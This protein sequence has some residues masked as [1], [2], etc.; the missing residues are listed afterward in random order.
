MGLNLF[1]TLLTCMV[2]VLLAGCAENGCTDKA[3]DNYVKKARQDDGS[4]TYQEKTDQLKSEYKLGYASLVFAN[5]QDALSAAINLQTEIELF[6][7]NPTKDGLQYC[8]DAWLAARIPYGQTEAFRFS[9]GPIDDEGGPEGLID[10]WP[11][12]ASYIDYVVG[13]PD[14]GIINDLNGFPEIT[15]EALIGVNK[16]DAEENVS[17]GYH[18][19]EFLLWG[20]D[21]SAPVDLIPGQRS[22]TDYLEVDGTASNQGRRGD[23]LSV[24]AQVLIDQLQVMVDAWNPSGSGNYYQTFMVLSGDDALQNVLTGLATLS[25]SELAEISMLTAIENQ[26]ETGPSDFSDNTQQDFIQNAKGMRNVYSAIYK[27]LDGTSV[28][29]TSIYDV[30]DVE[31]SHLGYLI[32]ESTK[33]CI[34]NCEAIPTPFDSQLTKETVEGSKPIMSAVKSL[35]AQGEMFIEAGTNLGL[36]VS[37]L[38][39]P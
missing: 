2:L 27:K 19:I 30:L 5:Y 38:S 9:N 29:G 20:Q 37:V 25:K 22:S 28:V 39:V 1:R 11:M 26:E 7:E 6:L 36:T 34:S 23:Y 17:V 15:A 33:E 8:K 14:A 31:N 3:A 16:L 4:C 21:N 32:N 10:A 12:D 24:C 13:F 35:Q 18:A